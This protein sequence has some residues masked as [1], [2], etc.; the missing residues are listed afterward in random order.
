MNN[1]GVKVIL[2]TENNLSNFIIDEYPLHPGFEF[3]SSTHKSDYL[4]S[5]FMYHYGGGYTDIKNCTEDWNIYFEILDNSN[6]SFIGYQERR[7]KD[8]A[9]RPYREFFNELVG[10]GAFIFKP[11]TEFAKKWINET[12]IILDSRLELLTLNPGTYH[13]RAIY[14]GV[15]GLPDIFN[16]SKYPLQWN[17]IM[18]RV[19][20]KIQY[21][22]KDCFLNSLPYPDIKNYR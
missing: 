14:G 4:R 12:H 13:P 16:E 3:L 2:V 5:Y 18:G 17:E 9:Y 10:N 11:R 19:F 7:Y 21:E 8:I 6:K 15:Q 20:H 1:S 22:N